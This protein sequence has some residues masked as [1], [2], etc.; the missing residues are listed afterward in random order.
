LAA[1]REKRGDDVVLQLFG[2]VIVE[3]VRLWALQCSGMLA[4]AP[5]RTLS[6]A[7]AFASQYCSER[8][9]FEQTSKDLFWNS[10]HIY[11]YSQLL[12]FICGWSNTV[13]IGSK[14]R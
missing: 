14:Q 10:N 9:L 12:H 5:M 8:V 11:F 3:G 2:K 4:S 13:F 1:L 7:F 6:T